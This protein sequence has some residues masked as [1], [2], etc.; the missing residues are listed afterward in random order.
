MMVSN[1]FSFEQY[2]L[3]TIGRRKMPQQ[4]N[5]MVLWSAVAE[6][7]RLGFDGYFQSR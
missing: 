6:S 7:E 2:P 5:P 3:L 1:L 4:I